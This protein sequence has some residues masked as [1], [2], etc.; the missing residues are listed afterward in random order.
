ME[1]TLDLVVKIEKPIKEKNA[2]D[3]LN[4]FVKE[5]VEKFVKY[6]Y[7]RDNI[8]VSIEVNTEKIPNEYLAT[9]KLYK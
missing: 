6:G 9:M 5:E 8:E 7:E 1:K 3:I 4:D 2:L